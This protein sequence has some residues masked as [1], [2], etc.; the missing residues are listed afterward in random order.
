MGAAVSI[1]NAGG[2]ILCDIGAQSLSTQRMTPQPLP[3]AGLAFTTVENDGAR[4]YVHQYG[5]YSTS[6]DRGTVRQY[7]P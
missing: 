4:I 7:C 6:T 2:G 3:K 5:P 1:V